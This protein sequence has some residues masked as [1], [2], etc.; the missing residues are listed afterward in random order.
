MYLLYNQT[1]IRRELCLELILPTS[2]KVTV[3]FI[4]KIVKKS[5]CYILLNIISMLL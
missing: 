1:A 5:I 4:L 2:Q 3:I